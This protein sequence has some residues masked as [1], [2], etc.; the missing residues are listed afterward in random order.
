MFIDLAKGLGNLRQLVI[1]QQEYFAFDGVRQD[2]VVD[3]GR[4]LLAVPVDAT[5]SLLNVHRIPGQIE[6]KKN[7]CVLQVD[8]LSARCRAD[9]YLRTIRLFEAFL[10]GEFAAVVSTL[11]NHNTLAWVRLVDLLT[12]HFHAAQVSGKDHHSLV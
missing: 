10:G 11:E 1:E 8:A 5:D 3:L 6:V 4:V 2:E 12:E 7:P 9:H